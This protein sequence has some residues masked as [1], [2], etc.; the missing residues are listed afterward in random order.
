MPFSRV[1]RHFTVILL[2]A[3]IAFVAGS[4]APAQVVICLLGLNAYRRRRREFP[5]E[6]ETKKINKRSG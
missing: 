6:E 1:S 4:A 3:A 5:H 2:V